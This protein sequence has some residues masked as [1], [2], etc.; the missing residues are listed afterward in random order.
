MET[1]VPF[2]ITWISFYVH[3]LGYHSFIVSIFL[4]F[5]FDTLFVEGRR[6]YVFHSSFIQKLNIL[7]CFIY[8]FFY[9]DWIHSAVV[10]EAGNWCHMKGLICADCMPA[11]HLKNCFKV[12]LYIH[13]SERMSWEMFCKSL[14]LAFKIGFFSVNLRRMVISQS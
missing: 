6:K 5:Y 14:V 4:S 10:F 1:I 12:A 9:S 13:R 11:I 8:F 2:F 7:R 3:I